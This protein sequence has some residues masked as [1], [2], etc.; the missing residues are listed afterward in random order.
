VLVYV[1]NFAQYSRKR[2]SIKTAFPYEAMSG[3]QVWL[4]S[5][6]D[7]RTSIEDNERWGRPSSNSNDEVGAEMRDSVTAD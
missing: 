2:E 5:F 7:G 6:E 4:C 3:T 1:S